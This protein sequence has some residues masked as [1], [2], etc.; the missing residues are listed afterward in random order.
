[1]TAFAIGM[2]TRGR[3]D[4][5]L[6]SIVAKKEPFAAIPLSMYERASNSSSV[7]ARR[8]SAERGDTNSFSPGV[9][10]GGSSRFCDMVEEAGNTRYLPHGEATQNKPLRYFIS[11]SS[12]GQASRPAKHVAAS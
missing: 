6:L 9:Q 3:V 4:N 12:E 2:A 8:R 1:V 10:V 5:V 11:L 7:P